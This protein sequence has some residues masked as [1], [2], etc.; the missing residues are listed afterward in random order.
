MI[1]G[2]KKLAQG[3]I[4]KAGGDVELSGSRSEDFQVSAFRGEISQYSRSKSA[5]WSARA[6]DGRKLGTAY[7]EKGTPEA[8]AEAAASAVRN[9]AFMDDDEGNALADTTGELSFTIGER[10]G[11]L[12]GDAAKEFALRL[13][14]TC[15]GIDPRVVNVPDS[16]Y[17]TGMSASVVATGRGLFRGLV[18]R[19]GYAYTYLMVSDGAETEIGFELQVVRD[20]ARL[21]LEFI[22]REAV[23]K[24]VERL[25]AEEP[26]SGHPRCVM[27]NDAA[28]GLIGAFL[29][30]VSAES[31]QKGISKLAG[32]R[33]QKVGCDEFTVIDDPEAPGFGKAPFDDEGI[34]SPRIAIFDKGVFAEPL[35]TIYS[36][37]REGARPN[38]RGFR[39]SIKSRAS[40]GIINAF[41]PD[42]SE[43]PADILECAWDGILITDLEGLH[44]GLDEVSG[45][46]SCAAKGFTIE[47]GK[48][49]RAIKNFTVSGNFYTLVQAIVA[50]ANDRRTDTNASFSSPSLLIQSLAVSG[51]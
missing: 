48:R 2:M 3:A 32:R 25:G 15:K 45:D 1:D 38:G 28:S 7:T 44:A 35:Y 39:A 50:R 41:I 34:D 40:A 46:F 36:A 8:L 6:I 37:R 20:P 17:G 22:A 43:T 30:N 18:Q 23:R 13:E 47:S 24:G 33:G 49:G 9:A 4:A 10:S 5:G 19:Y 16:S 26:K 21:D 14:K 31:M 29:G 12:D 11:W 42:G 51:R 27:Q